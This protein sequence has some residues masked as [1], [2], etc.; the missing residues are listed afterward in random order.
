MASRREYDSRDALLYAWEKENMYGCY[1]DIIS[2]VYD[3]LVC[4]GL[5]SRKPSGLCVNN[6]FSVQYGIS[7]TMVS[8]YYDE[9]SYSL[10]LFTT[11]AKQRRLVKNVGET[12]HLECV[13]SPKYIE[14]KIPM[15]WCGVRVDEYL[16]QNDLSLELANRLGFIQYPY[17]TILRRYN[18]DKNY[19]N[20]WGKYD[21]CSIVLNN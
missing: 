21:I 11:N 4:C 20:Y 2:L 10:R 9:E 13:E 19:N 8:T 7:H 18:A 3:R 15:K 17:D 5:L 1:N 6:M 14:I 16:K 12:L